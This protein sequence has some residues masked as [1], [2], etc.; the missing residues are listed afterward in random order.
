ME[1]SYWGFHVSPTGRLE[2]REDSVSDDF[3]NTVLSPGVWYHGAIVKNGDSGANLSFYLN[4][5]AD[6]MASVG[7]SSA[8]GKKAIG[9]KSLGMFLTA[10]LMTS[11]ST[12]R[13]LVQVRWGNCILSEY[14]LVIARKTCIS[15]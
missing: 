7:A 11:A 14:N 2:Y 6:G 8:V 3:G 9:M 15:I 13:P 1:G 4:G 5:V 10:S 12:T